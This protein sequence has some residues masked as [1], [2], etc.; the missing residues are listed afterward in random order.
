L[1]RSFGSMYLEAGDRLAPLGAVVIWPCCLIGA[2]SSLGLWLGLLVGLILAGILTS[3]AGL[4]IRVA[5][6]AVLI[7]TIALFGAL[8]SYQG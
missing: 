5:W 6:P 4:V 3:A 2:V 7:G 8:S 1:K